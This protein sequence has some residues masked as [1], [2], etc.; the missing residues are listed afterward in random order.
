MSN[1][2]KE[3]IGVTAIIMIYVGFLAIW[4]LRAYGVI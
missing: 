1:K 2:V 3:A 4:L